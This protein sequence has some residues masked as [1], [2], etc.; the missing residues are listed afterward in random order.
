[1]YWLNLTSE[2]LF[3][4]I[5]PCE[6]G[7]S[8][9]VIIVNPLILLQINQHVFAMSD[10]I[11]FYMPICFRLFHQPRYVQ[12][13]CAFY[14]CKY[15]FCNSYI[16]ILCGQNITRVFM[17]HVIKLNVENT[18][19]N[20]ISLDTSFAREFEFLFIK[21]DSTMLRLDRWIVLHFIAI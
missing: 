10:E 11:G 19:F 8:I 13:V 1:M 6:Y 15:F 12:N 7:I 21:T 5:Y 18:H 2:V 20:A 3:E 17:K 9:F 16:N 4:T 14:S